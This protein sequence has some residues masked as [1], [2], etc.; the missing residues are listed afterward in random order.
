L[1]A[2]QPRSPVRIRLESLRQIPS[3]HLDIHAELSGR[4]DLRL[5]TAKKDFDWSGPE[6]KEA[7]DEDEMDDLRK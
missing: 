5:S 7:Q 2:E 3:T 6:G 1:T 4:N